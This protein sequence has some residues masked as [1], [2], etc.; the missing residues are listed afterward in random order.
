M[1]SRTRGKWRG[2]TI[3]VDVN[4]PI[5]AINENSPHH[6]RLRVWWDEQLSG[7]RPVGLTWNVCFAFVR[8]TTNP[9]IVA[10]PLSVD[11]ATEYVTSWLNQ[12]CVRIVEPLDG[13][14][15]LA[16]SLLRQAG[17][18]GNLTTDA[19]LA[20]LAIEHGCVLCSTDTDF[21]R[22]PGLEWRNL[23]AEA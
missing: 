8:I 10:A 4:I 1:K 13:H 18:G 9:R 15:E 7:A 12:P 21:S 23:L 19:H 11:E 17:S 2:G 3:L 5:H 16:A 22:F 20:A 6:E 14:W